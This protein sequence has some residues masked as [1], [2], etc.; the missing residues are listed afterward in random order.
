MSFDQRLVAYLYFTD[1]IL[2]NYAPLSPFCS[3]QKNFQARPNYTDLLATPFL[4]NAASNTT[5]DMAAFITHALEDLPVPP[6]EK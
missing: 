2:R 5:V 4:T 1:K 6:L 3:L